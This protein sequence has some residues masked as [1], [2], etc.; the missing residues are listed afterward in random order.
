MEGGPD[1]SRGYVLSLFCGLTPSW[2][3]T[4]HQKGSSHLVELMVSMVNLMELVVDTHIY[5]RSYCS[6][7]VSDIYL[8]NFFTL[9]R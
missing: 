6:I 1:D 2:G 7:H 3:S 8:D 5:T 4:G 9:D